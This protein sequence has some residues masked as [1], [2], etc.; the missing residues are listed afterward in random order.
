P[1][2]PK[3]PERASPKTALRLCWAPSLTSVIDGPAGGAAVA[4]R[5]A[6]QPEVGSPDGPRPHLPL[7][8][9]PNSPPASSLRDASGPRPAAALRRVGAARRLRGSGHG[10]EERPGEGPDPPAFALDRGYPG[11][12]ARLDAGG[13]DRTPG[14]GAGRRV[15][16]RG[17]PARD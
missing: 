2:S 11:P 1:V 14:A 15:D 13:G 9:D 6:G 12:R 17:G 3:R 16:R 8:D 7:R 5:M 10:D 4:F